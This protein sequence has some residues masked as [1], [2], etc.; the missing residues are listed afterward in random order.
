MPPSWQVNYSPTYLSALSAI[1]HVP[2]LV[3]ANRDVA[4][5]CS[6]EPSLT[7]DKNVT[8]YR[9]SDDGHYQVIWLLDQTQG[10]NRAAEDEDLSGKFELGYRSNYENYH[11]LMLLRASTKDQGEYGCSVSV[12]GGSPHAPNPQ[13]MDV[14]GAGYTIIVRSK[15]TEFDK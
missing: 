3:I 14:E 2:P 13:Y 7:L 5:R 4:L 11:D 8:W 15:G 9:I 12:T 1:I 10:I 6:W